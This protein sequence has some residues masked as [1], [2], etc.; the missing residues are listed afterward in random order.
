[1]GY[2]KMG[3]LSPFVSASIADWLRK[4]GRAVRPAL[5]KRERRELE[6]CFSLMDADGS[7]AIDVEEM[8]EA[9]QLLGLKVS[10][11][12]VGEMLAKV[13]SDGSGKPVVAAVGRKYVV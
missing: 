11:Q 1:M 9:F 10:K 3:D 8:W 7:G 6:E 2:F 4:H 5:S 12:M 13:D